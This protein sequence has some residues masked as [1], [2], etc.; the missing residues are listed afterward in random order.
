MTSWQSS[1]KTVFALKI[2]GNGQLDARLR[3]II[4]GYTVTAGGL[5]NTTSFAGER[6]HEKPKQ[7]S[8]ELQAF[9][10]RDIRKVVNAW[11]VASKTPFDSSTH[12]CITQLCPHLPVHELIDL[13][14]LIG[15]P[16]I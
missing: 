6:D 10:V 16:N 5:Y 11:W 2:N 4:V 7:H 3:R 9:D 15:V 1:E 8:F 14:Q 13:D 12:F